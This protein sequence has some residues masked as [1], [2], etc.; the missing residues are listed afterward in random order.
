[1]LTK[2][3]GFS[4]IEALVA[5][6][7][8]LLVIAA[9]LA[10]LSSIMAAANSTLMLSRLNQ[11]LQ[12]VTDIISRDIQRTGYYSDAA[13]GLGSDY[14]FVPHQDLYPAGAS[15]HCIRVK[16]WDP[17]ARSGQE[18]VVKVYSH[19]AQQQT[20]RVRTDYGPPANVPLST[21][22]TTGQRLVSD[23]EIRIPNFDL[24]TSG[25]ALSSLTL[26]VAAVHAR[27]P[28]FSAELERF[29]Y[30]RNHQGSL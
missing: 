23:N 11:E 8:G 27:R 21:L 24:L 13:L 15:S 12:G 7:A 6:A 25:N 3:R 9:A 2:Q 17:T 30:L 22:C 5:L 26:R 18:S 28:L 14:L 4:L 29:V 1:M 16:F 10:L 19:D 20:L